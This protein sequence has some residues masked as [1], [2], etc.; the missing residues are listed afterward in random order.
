MIRKLHVVLL[1]LVLVPVLGFA[2]TGKITGKVTD[3]KT[4]EALPGANILVKELGRGAATNIEGTYTISL[5]E[6]G[7]Y[8]LQVSYVGYK[9]KEQKVEVGTQSVELTLSLDADFF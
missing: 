4:D 6:P 1:A 9:T 7:T 8:T 2:Q 3:S 5:L